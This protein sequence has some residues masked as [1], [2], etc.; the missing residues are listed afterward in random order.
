MVSKTSS[1]RRLHTQVLLLGWISTLR[2]ST[3]TWAEEETLNGS[4]GL[5]IILRSIDISQSTATAL[6]QVLITQLDL[7]VKSSS[8]AMTQLTRDEIHALTKSVLLAS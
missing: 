4:N 2:G 3:L 7:D 1:S 5:K 6:E 8:T